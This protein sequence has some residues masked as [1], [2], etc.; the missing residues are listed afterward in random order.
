M[1]GRRKGKQD[2]LGQRT[3]PEAHHIDYIFKMHVS[4][5]IGILFIYKET[6][7][8]MSLA[9]FLRQRGQRQII[10]WFYLGQKTGLE[11]AISLHVSP[12]WSISTNTFLCS[13]GPFPKRLFI[14]TINTGKLLTPQVTIFVYIFSFHCIH[15]SGASLST[16]HRR[17]LPN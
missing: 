4:V 5:G 15:R 3:C 2:N 12:P 10:L 16:I 13:V 6:L 14:F 8:P 17:H 7:S 11:G 1:G 9:G